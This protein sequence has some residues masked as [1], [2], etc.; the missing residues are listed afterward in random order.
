M[1]KICEK[2][3]AKNLREAAKF[4]EDNV[5][6]RIA[7][8]NADERTLSADIYYHSNCLTKYIQKFNSAK[9]SSLPKNEKQTGKRLVFQHYVKFIEE[10]IS[11]GK[12]ITLTEIRDMI[13]TK[14]DIDIKN[15]E[16]K[17]FLVEFLGDS[18]QFC[19]SDRKNKPLMVFSS[20]L[21][22][23]D[24]INTLRALHRVKV[25]A[26]V[27]RSKLLNVDFG[28]QDKFCDVE[29]LKHSW[30]AT[31]IPDELLIFFAE[32][33][34][35]KKTTMLKEYYNRNDEIKQESEQE[36]DDILK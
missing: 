4:L 16:V 3:R 28:L 30:R 20:S 35:I 10:V 24:V 29:E 7:D 36:Q 15:N 21:D 25:A 9:S 14:E 33:F 34:N 2:N 18:I 31:K 5:Y 13:N 1:F 11:R 19:E 32:L 26:K 8:L 23:S 27:I 6:T 17:S 22:I 12:G